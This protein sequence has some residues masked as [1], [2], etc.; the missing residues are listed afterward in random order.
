MVKSFYPNI[1]DWNNLICCQLKFPEWEFFFSSLLLSSLLV[2]S[3]LFPETMSSI[4]SCPQ[5]FMYVPFAVAVVNN[6]QTC[7]YNWIVFVHTRADW[8]NSK[9]PSIFLLTGCHCIHVC[10]GWFVQK[11]SWLIIQFC[12]EKTGSFCVVHPWISKCL[13]GDLR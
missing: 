13:L 6:Q 2:S 1:T 11:K 12:R 5:Y 8:R 7:F 9:L 3:L 10:R 4:I